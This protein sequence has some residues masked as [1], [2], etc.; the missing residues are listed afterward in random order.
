MT[1]SAALSCRM[2]SDYPK[3]ETHRP[4]PFVDATSVK[5]V[6]TPPSYLVEFFSDSNNRGLLE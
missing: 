2:T 6:V 3:V 1:D 4:R 5:Y